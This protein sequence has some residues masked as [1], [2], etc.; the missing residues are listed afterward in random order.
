[1]KMTV[2][3]DGMPCS[4]VETDRRFRGAYCMYHR[5]PDDEGS[6]HLWNVNQFPTDAR[7]N[8]L[9]DSHGS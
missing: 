1:M 7:R 3:W 8:I 2:F 9:E 5:R 4:L 6:K